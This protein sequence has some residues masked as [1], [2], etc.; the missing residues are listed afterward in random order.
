MDV[1]E[2]LGELVLLEL[3][4]D[5]QTSQAE[6]LPEPMRSEHEIR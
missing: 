2:L 3:L 1:I 4:D 5:G 6:D